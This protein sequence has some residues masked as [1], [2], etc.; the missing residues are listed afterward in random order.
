MTRNKFRWFQVLTGL[1]VGIH[2]QKPKIHIGGA[3]LGQYL[4]HSAIF[5]QSKKIFGRYLNNS[6]TKLTW[7]IIFEN[8]QHNCDSVIIC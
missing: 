3:L 8:I 5:L 4:T 1:F 2:K 7:E 6:K